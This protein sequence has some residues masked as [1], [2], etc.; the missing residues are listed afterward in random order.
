MTIDDKPWDG[1][2]GMY[3]TDNLNLRQFQ[4]NRILGKD[5]KEHS[6]ISIHKQQETGSFGRCFLC[7]GLLGY[8]WCMLVWGADLMLVMIYFVACGARHDSGDSAIFQ[9]HL[10][11]MCYLCYLLVGSE[12]I[13]P[14]VI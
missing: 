12:K 2:W 5:R 7:F 10:R 6:I 13:Y 14:L 8:S 9:L 11:C 3:L 1:F 4:K